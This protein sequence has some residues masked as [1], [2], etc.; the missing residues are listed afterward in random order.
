[1]QL[2]KAEQFQRQRIAVAL[3][4]GDIAAFHQPVEH[5]VEFVRAAIQMLGD[6]GL[7][8]SAVNA[9]QQFE[10]IQAL[11]QRG[12][13]VAVIGF[14]MCSPKVALREFPNS[15]TNIVSCESRICAIKRLD[16]S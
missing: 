10:D 2:G 14:Q 15:Y 3:K 16:R 6:L 12:R 9:S 11:V 7:R 1:M 4:L 13:A 8:Q 5:T